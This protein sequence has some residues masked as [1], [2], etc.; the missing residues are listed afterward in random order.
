MTIT[1]LEESER[2]SILNWMLPYEK[3]SVTLYSQILNGAS[4]VYVVRGNF[5]E[6][7]GVFSWYA[8]S[9]IHH[10]LPDVYG[11]NRAEMENAFAVFFK[12][13]TTD[14][15]FSVSGEE[16][17]TLMIKKV[18]E[19]RLEKIPEVQLEYYLMENQRFDSVKDLSKMNRQLIIENAGEEEIESL[20]KLQEAFE[21]EEVLL[22]SR[23][24]NRDK[25]LAKF[26]NFIEANAVYVGKIK[27]VPLCK[28]TV[29]C[30]GLNYALIAGVY[31][32]P[33][34]RGHGLA[35]ALVNSVTETLSLKKKKSVLFVKKANKAAIKV[36][37]DTGFKRFS[38][39]MI[40]YY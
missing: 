24:F 12:E 36:Y 15:L 37:N 14:Y 6:I 35:K 13:Y 38:D 19:E 11:K 33:G 25:S 32:L 9:S 21:K 4:A 34:Y 10:C 2:N 18:L 39:Y 22:D 29:S 20:F 7:H 28:L 40:L 26:E 30:E 8:G 23:D 31:T 17:G 5:G 3:F 27:N 1:R 16:A